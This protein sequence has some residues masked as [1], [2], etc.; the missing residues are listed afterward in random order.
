MSFSSSRTMP[1]TLSSRTP[2]ELRGDLTPC[3]LVIAA[4]ALSYQQHNGIAIAGSSEA[5]GGPQH[6]CMHASSLGRS[7]ARRR[8]RKTVSNRTNYSTICRGLKP[9]R[10][11]NHECCCMYLLHDSRTGSS[12]LRFLPASATENR[13][14][15][16][17]C[18]DSEVQGQPPAR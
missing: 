6:A 12:G 7:F 15:S 10:L 2:L 8:R 5:R 13:R 16:S 14:V 17:E 11:T 9:L 4:P 18:L 1:A 3:P